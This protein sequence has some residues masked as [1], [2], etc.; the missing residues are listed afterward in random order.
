MSI[1]DREFHNVNCRFCG[2]THNVNR[3]C[4]SGISQVIHNVNKK[5]NR[6][7]KYDFLCEL[8]EQEHHISFVRFF[9]LINIYK[10]L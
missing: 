3:A 4:I 8:C 10:D 9:F 2:A 7:N 5:K 6:A 1:P